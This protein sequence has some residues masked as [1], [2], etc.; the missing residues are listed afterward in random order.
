MDAMSTYGRFLYNGAP[1]HAK[2]ETSS[3]EEIAHFIENLFENPTP[4]GERARVAE[5]SILPPVAPSKLF[6]IGLNYAA[7]AK[8]HGSE[9]PR[10]PLM[11]FKAP[12]SLLAHGGEIEIAFPHHRTDFEAELALIIGKRGKA[13]AESEALDYIFG[14][15]CAQDI[16][17]RVIQ[18]DESQWARAKSFDTYTPLGPYITR[19]LEW[20]N[21][22][23]ET[24]L[25]GETRQSGHTSEM[26]FSPA[27]I[28]SFVS[29][30]ITLEAGDVIL[31][32]TPEGVGALK[33]GDKLETR[34]SGL[35]TL[36]NSVK[37]SA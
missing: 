12:S 25:N 20:G 8:E 23:V 22:T 5:L 34:I 3:G 30:H 14:A 13:I 17:D 10:E 31:T 15:T 9:I 21:L 28:V 35:K 11:W 1:R 32:G 6:A 33:A 2:I 37:N 18:R 29:Q 27:R 36:L 19:D 24:V 16:S 4:T 7:H 26:I